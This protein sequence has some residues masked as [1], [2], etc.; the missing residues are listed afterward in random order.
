MRFEF[1]PLLMHKRCLQCAT[2]NQRTNING[3]LEL[4]TDSKAN[5]SK[6]KIDKMFRLGY[7]LAFDT[8]SKKKKWDDIFSLWYC[9]ATNGH[10][11]AQFYLA[12]CYDDGL[13]T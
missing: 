8:K 2:T 6:T 9:A 7:K 12:T 4:M 5:F 3:G 10:T 13:G 11:R 1:P